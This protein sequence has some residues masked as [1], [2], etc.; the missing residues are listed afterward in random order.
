MYYPKSLWLNMTPQKKLCETH[1][2]Y[3]NNFSSGINKI[4]IYKSKDLNE[5]ISEVQST[6]CYSIQQ[7]RI[8]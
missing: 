5:P 4:D 8:L 3:T 2:N 1:L 6:V 7:L